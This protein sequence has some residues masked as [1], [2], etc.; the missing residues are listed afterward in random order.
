MVESGIG[1]QWRILRVAGGGEGADGEL[2]LHFASIKRL[3][4]PARGSPFVYGQLVETELSRASYR[5]ARASLA[6]RQK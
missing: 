5:A 1:W 4:H 2:G 6:V 3:P